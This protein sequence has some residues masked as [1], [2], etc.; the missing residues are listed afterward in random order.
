MSER[1]VDPNAVEVEPELIEA[2]TAALVSCARGDPL[3]AHGGRD[4]ILELARG[5]SHRAA[6]WR[7]SRYAAA[8]PGELPEFW[9][10]GTRA[11]I[12]LDADPKPAPVIRTGAGPGYYRDYP[13]PENP[14]QPRPATK[15]AG[16]S[17]ARG[18]ALGLGLSAL[19]WYAVGYL[20]AAVCSYWS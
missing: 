16:D 14:T 2:A 10:P 18:L 5:L 12:E 4:G 11:L 8:Q 17:P 7:Y 1:T 15:A 20:T 6:Q 3:D 19:L 9:A 13:T